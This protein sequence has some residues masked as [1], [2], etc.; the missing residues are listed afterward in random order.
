MKLIKSVD[1]YEEFLRDNHMAETTV[2]AYTFTIKQYLHHHRS[3]S[4]RSLDSHK[5]FMLEN[6]KPQTVNQKIC[7]LN[8]YICFMRDDPDPEV[9]ALF[10]SIKTLRQVR[11]QQKFYLE[12]VISDGE[13]NYLK[14]RLLRDGNKRWYFILR[15][16]A[17]SGARVSELVQMKYEHL[18]AGYMEICSK[19]GKTRR[20]LIPKSLCTEAMAFYQESGITSGFVILNASG[21]ILSPRG[22][23]AMLR[24]FAIKYNMNENTM[25]PHA[26]RHL[27][28]QNFLKKC[29][30]I[31]L[32][33]DL[34]GHDSI[35]T[36]R[37]YLKKTGAE[38]QK[39][40]NK[41]VTW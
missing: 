37:I 18:E 36:T 9:A 31:A 22:I 8:Q 39:L 4:A 27:Y 14:R 21:S 1:A 13:F 30:D 20:I 32:L 29:P 38:Q 10:R 5:L 11:I 41:V 26:F 33:A 6:Y 3:F 19:A 24:K 40:I 2:R 25:H 28:A 35:E 17:S 15:L 34:L 7:A 23:N 16:M 12:N